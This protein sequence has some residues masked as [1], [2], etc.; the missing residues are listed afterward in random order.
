[1]YPSSYFSFL[2]CFHPNIINIYYTG[3]HIGSIHNGEFKLCETVLAN[4]EKIPLQ[5]KSLPEP[6]PFAT[7]EELKKLVI[8][9]V[10]SIKIK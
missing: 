9:V 1:M 6:R 3:I 7:V 5:I 8:D 10:N 2:I 4:G